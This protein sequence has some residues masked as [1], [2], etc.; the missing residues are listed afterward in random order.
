MHMKFVNPMVFIMSV[1]YYCC[2]KSNYSTE[3]KPKMLF[4]SHVHKFSQSF[5]FVYSN[6]VIIVFLAVKCVAR[7]V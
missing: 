4:L 7:L 5:H 6:C 2:F 3:M 1:Q